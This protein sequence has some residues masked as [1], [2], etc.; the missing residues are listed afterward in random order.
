MG[1]WIFHHSYDSTYRTP[2][3]AVKTN[4]EVTLS[5]KVR[6]Y[7]EII[8]VILHLVEDNDGAKKELIMNVIDHQ[9]DMELYQ[10]QIQSPDK[11]VLLWYYFEVNI[12]GEKYFYGNNQDGYGGKGEITQHIPLAY[13][14]TVYHPTALPP[15]W[16]KDSIIYQIFVDRFYNGN[17]DNRI[18]KPKKR[19]LLH[20]DWDNDPIYIKD[21]KGGI[22]YWDFFG[23]NLLGVQKKLP[24]LK[25][26]GINV[27]Y[28]NP[29]FESVSNHKYD[30]GDYHKIDPMF[31]DNELFKEFCQ[32]AKKLGIHI[33]LDGVFSHTGSDSIYFNKDGNYDAIGAYQSKTSPY[34]NWYQFTDH[35]NDYESWWG[36][37]VLPNVNELEPS[38]QDFIIYNEKSVLKY[39]QR[40]GAKGWRLDV[41][42][43]LPDRFIRAFKNEMQ[44]QDSESIL[45]GEVW[46]DASNKISY[47]HR[48]RYIIDQ[49][50]DSVTNYPFRQIIIDFLLDQVDAENAHRRLMSLYENYPTH[51]FYSTMN[52]I[53]THD[54]PRILSVLQ[55]EL[56]EYLPRKLR[57]EIGL[58]R[59]KLASLWQMT[60]PGVPLIFYGDEVGGEGEE[61]P[62]NR[63]TFPWGKE[64]IELQDWYK[65]ISRIR[66]KHAVLRTGK[67]ISLPLHH[68]VY[69]YIRIIKDSMDIFQQKK[70]SNV[71]IILLNRNKNQHID[72]DVDLKRWIKDER[73]IDVLQQ[74]EISINKGVLQ[75]SLQPL[76]GKLLM[77]KI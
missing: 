24:Y 32:E 71:A 46:E 65:T 66:N 50:L 73:L 5:L 8:T 48:R 44:K 37:D 49:E 6:N 76:E 52:I 14:I 51:H 53:G 77:K 36:I 22:I 47:G 12:N 38:Y 54:T 34:Y 29:I 30:T 74:K 7:G 19:S 13:Q 11:P 25:Q 41:A 10:V 18:Q 1:D 58:K 4:E 70:E 63:R 35:P 40:M 15:N 62:L 42:D 39:W 55:H 3:G 27:I 69:G 56:P 31:G 2:F 45:I 33:I 64:N 17:Q 20:S 21:E 60:F 67:W 26:L 9:E 59:L 75:I 72:L 23:G 16:Y 68:D 43:E 28:F 57:E 61:E